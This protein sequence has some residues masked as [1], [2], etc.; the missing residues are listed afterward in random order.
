MWPDLSRK[1]DPEKARQSLID[2]VQSEMDRI[3]A[4]ATEH[5]QKA[6]DEPA[7]ERARRAF[8]NS[9]EAQSMIR[10]FLRSKGARSNAGSRCFGR[11]NERGRRT[12]MR[13]TWD[14]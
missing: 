6:G 12:A 4:I 3:W 13:R 7:W 14:R 11:R 1:G 2:L 8:V 9:P 5:E 10:S